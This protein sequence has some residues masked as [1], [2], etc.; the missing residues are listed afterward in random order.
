MSL[1]I[2]ALFRSVAGVSSAATAAYW[3]GLAGYSGEGVRRVWTSLDLE[4]KTSVES[5]TWSGGGAVPVS[6]ITII[7]G[8]HSVPHPVFDLP[9]ILGPT[10]HQLDGPEVIWQFFSSAQQ[11]PR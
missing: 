6:L 11:G 4:D 5:V 9:R 1:S 2:V 7:G 8:G 10:S 3:A